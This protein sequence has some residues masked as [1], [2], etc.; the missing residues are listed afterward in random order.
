MK[1]IKIQLVAALL[2]IGGMASA[3]KVLVDDADAEPR[4]INGSFNAIHI[5]GS[6]DLY[7]SQYETER[8]AV[9]ASQQKYRD[10]IKTVVENGVLRISFDNN[11]WN[12]NW[13]SDKKKMKVYLSFKT[14]E[15]IVATGSSDVVVTGTI[16]L[17]NLKIEMSGSSDFKGNVAVQNLA[18]HLSGS[19]DAR[20][21]G[22]ADNIK[23]HASGASDL[24]AY[25][26]IADYCEVDASGASDVNITV[27][28][29]IKVQAS[30]ASD[31]FYKGTAVITD[32][33][34]SGASTVS[35]R[36]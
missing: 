26:L 10:A 21:S 20:L 18:V 8:M 30:G 4:A 32:I 27:N 15:R 36:S 31:V 29:E 7:L 3:Q 13:N 19:S 22:K 6:I 9:S 23:L 2:L 28:K 34:N 24:K 35:R 14:L 1:H 25:E 16:Q 11:G 17:S 12:W 5:S 33:K